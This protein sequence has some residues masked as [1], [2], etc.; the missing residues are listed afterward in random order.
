MRRLVGDRGVAGALREHLPGDRLRVAGL[1]RAGDRTNLEGRGTGLEDHLIRDIEI[2][3]CRGGGPEVDPHPV[4]YRPRD[5]EATDR[6]GGQGPTPKAGFVRRVD[7][8]ALRVED[9]DRVA[10]SDN[11]VDVEIRRGEGDGV[12]GVASCVEVD[13]SAGVG[14][15]VL[16]L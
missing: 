2:G 7:E 8:L 6:R 4:R 3:R 15:G 10:G 16:C 13:L 11:T 9:V 1:R 14:V 12:A 5:P